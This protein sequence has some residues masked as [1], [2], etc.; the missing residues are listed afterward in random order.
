M[1]PI[2]V[3]DICTLWPF[4]SCSGLKEWNLEIVLQPNLEMVMRYVRCISGR[5]TA[6]GPGLGFRKFHR[7][8]HCSR[9]SRDRCY[10]LDFLLMYE[11]RDHVLLRRSFTCEGLKWQDR[12]LLTLRRPRF[13]CLLC[14]RICRKSVGCLVSESSIN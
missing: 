9:A 12:L 2:G 6:I 3:H 7:T 4:A 8:T 10:L 1:I 14:C 5:R 13:V 11:C